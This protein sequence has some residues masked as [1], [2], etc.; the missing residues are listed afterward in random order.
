MNILYI[1]YIYKFSNN[2]NKQC[3]WDL[4]QEKDE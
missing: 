2:N 3:D 4:Y 1:L